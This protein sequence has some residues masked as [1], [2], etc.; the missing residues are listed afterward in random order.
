[1]S[2]QKDVGFKEN[3][4][5]REGRLNRWRYFKRSIAFGMMFF[6]VI[7]IVVIAMI[8]INPSENFSSFEAVVFKIICIAALYPIFCLMVRRLHDIDENEKIAYI[9]IALSIASIILTDLNAQEK[10][11]YASILSLMNSV[12]NIYVLLCPGTKGDN[13]YGSDP[14]E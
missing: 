12:I 6:L 14:L 8:F 2:R 4:L 5:K 3:F 7:L 10:S 13:K 11:L 1:M 9:S